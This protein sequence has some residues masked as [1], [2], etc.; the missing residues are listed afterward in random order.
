MKVFVCYFIF[1]YSY[2]TI[3]V[4][5]ARKEEKG[6]KKYRKRLDKDWKKHGKRVEKEGRYFFNM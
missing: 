5:Y 6:W 3:P 2:K 1:F 4:F